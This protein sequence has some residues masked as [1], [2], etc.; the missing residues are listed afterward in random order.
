[1][2]EPQGTAAAAL[3]ARKGLA[4]PAGRA[5][6]AAP[7]HAATAPGLEAAALPE[8]EA[9]PVRD[10]GPAPAASLLPVDFLGAGE[11]PVDPAR[12]PPEAPGLAAGD[13]KSGDSPA[14]SQAPRADPA[15]R[16]AHDRKRPAWRAGRGLPALAA[17][18]G[19]AALLGA[20]WQAHQ[21]GWLDFKA[22]T[23]AAPEAPALAIPEQN[24]ETAAT[25]A[26]TSQ[27]D[28]REPIQPAIDVARVG[29]DGTAVIAGRAAPG[30]ELIVLDN[31]APIGTAAAD[32]F[33][34][35]VFIPATPLPRGAH[36]FGLVIK[37]V[38]GGASVPAPENGRP[39]ADRASP[40]TEQ[41]SEALAPLPARKP[42]AARRAPPRSRP[43]RD[44]A[45][46]LAA[47]KTRAGAQREWRELQRRFPEVLAGMRPRLDE[48]KLG[49]GLSVVRL[50]TGAFAKRRDAAALCQRLETGRQGCLVVRASIND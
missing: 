46:Q 31:G 6:G 48:A 47:V 44:F 37:K 45:V 19:L 30:A 22:R 17:A 35:W 13:P 21:T 18:L 3:L 14:A 24:V 8:S 10:A 1:M 42:I 36:E 23:A 25:P 5:R 12:L 40:G 15:W 2:S 4:A 38:R 33:G 7:P 32:A 11:R 43:S 28:T 34:E 50:R 9:A 16:I 41:R 29:P 39:E 26:K 49:D 20:G 27:P